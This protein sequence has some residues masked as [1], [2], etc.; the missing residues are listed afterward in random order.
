MRTSKI[1]SLHNLINWVNMKNNDLNL[2]KL[3]LCTIPLNA[4]AWLSGFIAPTLRMRRERL[5]LRLI[6]FNW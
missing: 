3:P 2:I 1:Y 4:D 6:Y 5:I